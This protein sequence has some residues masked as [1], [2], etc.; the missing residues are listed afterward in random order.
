MQQNFWFCKP[1]SSFK[2]GKR[3]KKSKSR[4]LSKP[5]NLERRQNKDLY[6]GL[7]P[8]VKHHKI[9]THPP[10][11]PRRPIRGSHNHSP[12]KVLS[13]TDRQLFYIIDL[14]KFL[15]LYQ[16]FYNYFIYQGTWKTILEYI[17]SQTLHTY[18]LTC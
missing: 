4:T 5:K 2:G 6:V 10:P 17:H 13:I 11:P 15:S 14:G 1:K 9:D 18:A 16:Y 12:R 3:K 8:L 7:L